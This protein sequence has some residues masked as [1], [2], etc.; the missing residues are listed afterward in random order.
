MLTEAVR[1]SGWMVLLDPLFLSQLMNI[2]IVKNNKQTVFMI[3]VL[4]GGNSVTCS[5]NYQF[6][7][8]T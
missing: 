1:S 8:G 3:C 5:K 7:T 6:I 2:P 4:K